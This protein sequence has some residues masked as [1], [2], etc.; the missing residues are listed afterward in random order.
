MHSLDEALV[1]LTSQDV[2]NLSEAA[3]KLHTE[4]STL[5][6]KFKRQSGSRAQAAEKKQ[7][8]SIKQEKTLIK[9]T[10]RHCERGFPL[11]P[12]MV[13]ILQARSRR[14]SLARNGLQDL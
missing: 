7:L 5:S 8:L 13:A 2:P 14:N 4:R 1:F 3:R 11:T 9:D 6:K 10:N 12:C